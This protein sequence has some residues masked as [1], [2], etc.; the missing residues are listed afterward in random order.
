MK[1]KIRSEDWLL[2]DKIRGSQRTVRSVDKI[3]KIHA[4]EASAVEGVSSDWEVERM[5]STY[6]TWRP[7]PSPQPNSRIRPCSAL[8]GR[9]IARDQN[10]IRLNPKWKGFWKVRKHRTRV[11][12]V[13]GAR[14]SSL[15]KTS[16]DQMEYKKMRYIN[17]GVR[18]K[19][20]W[21]KMHNWTSPE[22]L[23]CLLIY[24][25]AVSAAEL[26]PNSRMW[27]GT[28]DNFPVAL[29]TA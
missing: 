1:R 12:T 5:E 24:E 19:R 4:T 17:Y 3:G 6:L 9:K 8:L 21:N 10:L 18:I 14:T 15:V 20:K 22:P 28:S 29:R 26:T 23:P 27:M 16:G 25:F 7:T 2:S 13:G 11:I